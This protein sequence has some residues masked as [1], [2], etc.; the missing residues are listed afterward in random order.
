MQE[1]REKSIPIPD[2]EPLYGEPFLTT[3]EELEERLS[4][5]TPGLLKML[6]RLEGDITVLGVGGKMGPTLAR[7]ARRGLDA[8]GKKQKVLGVARFSDT[9]TQAKLESWGVETVKCDLLDR[10]DVQKLPITPNVIYMAGQKFGTTDNPSLTWAMNTVAPAYVAERFVGARTVVFSTGCV[11]PNSPVKYGGAREFDPLEPLGEYANSCIGREQVF[12]HFAGIYHTPTLLFRLNYAI[13]LRYGVL[14]DIAR[15][16]ADGEPI[17]LT[18]GHVNVIWQGDANAWAI[19]CLEHASGTPRV[20][21]ITGPETISVRRL[22]E[23][24]GQ[25]F[26]RAPLFTGEEAKTALLSNAERAFFCFGYPSVTL[27]QMLRWT[28]AWVIKGNPTWDKPTH[29]EARDGKF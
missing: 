6:E 3:E 16:V 29:F 11:Y 21:N 7:M 25:Y 1:E 9:E 19:Q 4:R 13:D 15:K 8:V 27:E 26:R 24:F 18:M 14:M 23:E 17:D 22:A 12:A 28:V 10:E 2:Q 5:P 20:M